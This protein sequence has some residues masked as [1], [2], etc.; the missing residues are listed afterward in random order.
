VQFVND[1]IWGC[2]VSKWQSLYDDVNATW[3]YINWDAMKASKMHFVFVKVGQHSY[4]DYTFE[5]N[6]KEA[7]RVGIPR[8]SYWYLD[9]RSD[10]RAQAR[11]YWDALK[12]DPG[13]GPLVVDYEQAGLDYDKLW[14]FLDELKNIS[15]YPS[16]RIWI[17]TGYYYWIDNS[18]L[19]ISKRQWF[20]QFPLWIAWYSSSPSGVEIPDMWTECALWQSGTPKLG[21][22]FGCQS[23]EIDYNVFNGGESRF[24]E[25][26][27][28]NEVLP[29][30]PGETMYLKVLA[31]TLNIRSSAAALLDNSNDLGSFNLAA[32]DIVEVT[33]SGFV[34]GTTTWRKILKIWRDN[35]P[36][37]FPASPTGEYWTAERAGLS[38]YMTQTT[39][40]PPVI[41]S[42]VVE[43]YIDGVK[44]FSQD[45][46]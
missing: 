1:G 9:Y 29:S 42:H 32:G 3:T 44:V 33:D 40:T 30:Q 24:K 19:E 23:R 22:L 5:H 2:D 7:K 13:E 31:T 14:N 46:S 12:G 37:S 20:A 18:P 4:Y 27:I 28:V 41:A 15:G 10:P 35:E 17:Y 39:F 21:I 43:V 26:F 16:H 36:V 38:I 25:Y 34:N 45:L 6:W 8:A 11:R